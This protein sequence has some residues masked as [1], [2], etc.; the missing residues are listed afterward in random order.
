MIERMSLTLSSLLHPTTQVNE[1]DNMESISEHFK[2]QVIDVRRDNRNWF[3]SGFKGTVRAGQVLRIR[4]VEYDAEKARAASGSKV[5][6]CE[7]G[8]I[9]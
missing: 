2:V 5:S 8:L 1:N 3:T 7:S 9:D 6:E 4:N